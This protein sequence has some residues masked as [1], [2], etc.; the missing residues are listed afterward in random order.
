MAKLT[1]DQA[2]QRIHRE[3]EGD[4]DYLEFEDEETQLRVEYIKD[5]IRVWQDKFPKYREA[6]YALEDA[7]D[8][9]VVTTGSDTLYDCPTNFIKPSG[10]VKIGDSTYFEYVDPSEIEKLQREDPSKHW[11]TVLGAPG[12]YRIRISHAQAA[13]LDIS[14]DYYG[15]VTMPTNTTSLIPIAR[16]LFTVYYTLWKLF[17]EDDPIRAKEQKDMMDEQERLERVELA[18]TPGVPNRL[19]VGGAGLNDTS[20]SVSNILTGE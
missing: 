1:V 2:L 3:Y 20:S 4:T 6:Y 15:E 10:K 16:P 17:S 5:G 9:D 18:D 13:G 7:D 11:F 14:Y 8:G 12:A 19:S